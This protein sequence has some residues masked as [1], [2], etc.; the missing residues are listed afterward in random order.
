[1][2]KKFVRAFAVFCLLTLFTSA[3]AYAEDSLVPGQEELMESIPDSASEILGNTKLD[4]TMDTDGIFQRILEKA[5]SQLGTFF[6]TAAVGAGGVLAASAICSIASGICPEGSKAGY[7]ITTV[8]VLVIAVSTAAGIGSLVSM[9]SETVTEIC[10]FSGAL[11]PV[12]ASASAMA[13][14]A[15]S[16]AAKYA[17]SILFIDLLMTLGQKLV[18]PLINMYLAVSIAS[19]AFGGHFNSVAKLIAKVV[20]TLLLTIAVMFTIYLTV[21]GLIASSADAAAVKVTKTAISTL[22]PV[23][24]GMVSD[25]A[26]AVASGVAVVKSV[27]GVFG[28]LVICAV[29][30]APLLRLAVCCLMY[31]AAAALSE[32]MADRRI[33]N[34]VEAI[35]DVCGMSLGLA[36]T[37]A[38]MLLVA[39]VSVTK[40]VTGA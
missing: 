29:C 21:T 2:K 12:L 28:V 3:V 33:T 30:A 35:S 13:G 27:A 31:K 4:E 24:G 25:A 37:C 10:G 18:L 11:L 40:A 19:S 20:K 36:G 9:A 6:R 17:A 15:A 32:T 5:V 34:L 8:G 26:D 23:V 22:L 14:A 7:A 38:V 1:M 39:I 16:T